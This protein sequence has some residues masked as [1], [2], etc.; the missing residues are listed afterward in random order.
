[1]QPARG[2]IDFTTELG[3]Y[4]QFELSDNEFYEI[5]FSYIINYYGCSSETVFLKVFLKDENSFS[6]VLFDSANELIT[7]STT[8]WNSL[9]R[10]FQ[11]D[12]GSYLL[13]ILA[14]SSCNQ[15]LSFVA[16]DAIY[17][18]RLEENEIEDVDSCLNFVVITQQSEVSH[19]ASLD[20]TVQGFNIISNILLGLLFD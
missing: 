11:V 3:F 4:K 12:S 6:E 10:C 1:M 16:V 15:P 20:P 5:D 9:K 8:M 17:I 2:I 18:K 7:S 13:N 14:T 19:E